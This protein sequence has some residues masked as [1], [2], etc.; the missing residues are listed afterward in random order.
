MTRQ[1]YD[2]IVDAFKLSLDLGPKKEEN[3]D[4]YKTV[5]IDDLLNELSLAYLQA[6]L[7]DEV[8]N[9]EDFEFCDE[10]YEDDE[11]ECVLGVKPT[12]EE[13]N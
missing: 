2:L 5:T 4:Y 12:K 11:E 10:D 7:A 3:W 1:D 6:T 9:D 13:L 8:A